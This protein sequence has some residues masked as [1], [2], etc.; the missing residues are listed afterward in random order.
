LKD[1]KKT[2]INL[3]NKLSSEIK[4][5]KSKTERITFDDKIDSQNL[6][7]KYKTQ[8]ITFGKNK[9]NEELKKKFISID[10]R[11]LIE[12]EE[13]ENDELNILE[14]KLNSDEVLNDKRKSENNEI[15]IPKLITNDK[16]LNIQKKYSEKISN[17]T[18]S[19]R[20]KN[21][22]LTTRYILYVK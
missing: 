17:R 18:P 3:K 8:K 11:K 20:E 4:I 16:E 5:K 21:L 22:L 1:I 14:T 7:Q 12:E 2:T 9:D 10:I 19:N 6:K 15:I 13:Y